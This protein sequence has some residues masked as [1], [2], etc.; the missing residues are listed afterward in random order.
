MSLKCIDRVVCLLY[1]LF[2]LV[3]KAAMELYLV[4]ELKVTWQHKPYDSITVLDVCYR[5]L[6]EVCSTII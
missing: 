4:S 6:Y 5:F 2:V 3:G 1:V